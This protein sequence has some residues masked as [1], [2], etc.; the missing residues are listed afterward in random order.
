MKIHFRHIPLVMAFL[1]ASCSISQ[2]KLPSSYD[3]FLSDSLC[4]DGQMLLL[5]IGNLY[6]S[7]TVC[8]YLENKIVL[9][10]L[11]RGWPF[12]IDTG[13][14]KYGGH[15]EYYYD[16]LLVW[17]RNRNSINVYNMNDPLKKKIKHVVVRDSLSIKMVHN[18]G[19]HKEIVIP[20]DNDSLIRFLFEAIDDTVR[21][22]TSDHIHYFE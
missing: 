9:K 19:N 11:Y 22:I 21:V 16:F 14:K 1:T 17:E 20:K 3:Q 15:G 2:H 7:D 18:K 6:P 4:K 10:N 8:V 13:A 12:P 5:E